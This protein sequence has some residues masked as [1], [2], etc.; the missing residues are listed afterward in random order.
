M[1]TS[2]FLTGI[3]GMSE[4]G[5]LQGAAADGRRNERDGVTRAQFA[6]GMNLQIQVS[7]PYL[8][9]GNLVVRCRKTGPA[10]ESQHT[11]DSKNNQR[12][13]SPRDATPMVH[14]C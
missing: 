1:T 3:A 2:P 12:E 7:A 11:D 6:G 4:S 14:R 5:N 9:N 10:R 13:R 8:T